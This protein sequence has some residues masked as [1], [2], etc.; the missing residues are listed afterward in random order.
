MFRSFLDDSAS[1][2]VMITEGITN[3]FFNTVF[4]AHKKYSNVN[5]TSL[6]KTEFCFWGR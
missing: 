1:V 6:Q 2:K 3:A 5:Q 4:V